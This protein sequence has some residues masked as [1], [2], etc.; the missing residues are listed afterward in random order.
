MPMIFRILYFVSLHEQVSD[1][2]V[3][4]DNQL[5]ASGGNNKVVRLWDFGGAYFAS[6]LVDV[7]FAIVA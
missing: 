5:L 3:S 4:P 6:V 1:L 7:V 2:A